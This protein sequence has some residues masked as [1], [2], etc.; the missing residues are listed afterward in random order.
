MDDSPAR[1]FGRKNPRASAIVIT[2][3]FLL[4]ASALIAHDRIS[5][6]VTWD[7]EIA[8]IVRARCMSCHTVGG[9]APMPLTTY[10]EARP[11]ARAIKEEVLTRR[12]PKWR[13]VRGYGDFA[14]DPSL[15]SFEVALI[16]AWADG[17]A[18]ASAK[19]TAGMP[20][21]PARATADKLALSSAAA[22]AP[23]TPV[24]RPP[25]RSTTLSCATRTLPAGRLVA[26]MPT[27]SEGGSLRL[28]LELADGT[29]EPVLWIREFDPGFL[30]TYWLRNPLTITRGTRFSAAFS[31]S[32]TLT[33]LFSART[34]R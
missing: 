32:C 33:A 28:N 13:V 30:E 25:T 16:A 8:P 7:R 11:W 27:L 1:V 24:D 23:V 12:M 5:T 10:E 34:A 20:S 18:P 9:R 22:T 6:K 26:L 14:N 4:S 31:G 29:A 21:D 2:G 17:G 3:T 15:S 19:A